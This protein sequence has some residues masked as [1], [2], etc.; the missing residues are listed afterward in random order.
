MNEEAS[1]I[2]AL[3]ADADDRTTLLV[4]AD[5][6]DEQGD[7]RAEL[8]RLLAAEKRDWNR[9][10]A[11]LPGLDPIWV[12]AVRDRIG[13]G[14]TVRITGGPFAGMVGTIT[15]LNPHGDKVLATVRLTLWGRS[16]DGE[17]DDSMIERTDPTD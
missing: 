5:W 17:L 10:G 14:C 7:S 8:V 15:A 4:Y 1:F 13:P 16:F 2:S 3:L 12:R 6:L 11:L 9:L